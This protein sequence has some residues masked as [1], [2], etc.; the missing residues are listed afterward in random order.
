[1]SAD[2]ALQMMAQLFWNCFL[3]AL[4]VLAVTLAVGVLISI[5]QVVTQLQESSLSYVPKLAAAGITLLLCGSW[6]LNRLVSFATTL[7]S[8]IPNLK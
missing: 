8:S 7:F 6:M 2:H 5:F 1:M 3:I 4:P